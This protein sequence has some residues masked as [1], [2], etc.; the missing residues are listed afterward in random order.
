MDTPII[1]NYEYT[2]NLYKAKQWLQSLPDLFAADFEIASKY[3]KQQKDVIKLRLAPEDKASETYR[4]F[5]QQLVSDGL[6]HPSLT[7]VTH[8]SVGWSERDSYVIVCD[9]DH[10]RKFVF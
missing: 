6:S 1:V 2:N 9:N 7:V 4:V 10:I 5:L 8:L 3:T